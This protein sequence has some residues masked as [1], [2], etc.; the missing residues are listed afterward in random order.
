M[1]ARTDRSEVRL[2]PLELEVM[3]VF[4]GRGALSVREALDLLPA[5]RRPAFTTVQTIVRRLEEKGA[6]RRSRKIGNALVFEPAMARRAA[7][8]RIVGNF[9]RMFGGRARPLVAHLAETGRLGLEDLRAAEDI[10]KSRR[11]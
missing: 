7:Y 1:A 4:W 9:L 11:S 5:R 2:S 3:E 6:L 10:L 8:A